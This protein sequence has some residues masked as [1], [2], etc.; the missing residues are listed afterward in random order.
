[1][2]FFAIL[3]CLLSL[4]EASSSRSPLKRA[5]GA[6]LPTVFEHETFAE[7]NGVFELKRRGPSSDSLEASTENKEGAGSPVL[8]EYRPFL[9]LP[10]RIPH[11]GSSA[12]SGAGTAVPKPTFAPGSGEFFWDDL[13]DDSAERYAQMP[14]K[15]V[16]S[17][18]GSLGNLRKSEKSFDFSS[19]S[20]ALA[21]SADFE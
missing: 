14:P 8:V 2:K 3:Y 10:T 11:K 12:A 17:V 4:T 19:W 20:A 6:E 16:P 18:S 9:R 13:D 7:G 21:A 15:E 1:M 5:R